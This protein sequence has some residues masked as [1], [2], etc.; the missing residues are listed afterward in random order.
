MYDKIFTERIKQFLDRLSKLKYSNAVPMSAE[1]LYDKNEPIPYKT[2]VKSKFKPIKV[3]DKWG[4]LW[5]CAWF[6]FKGEIPAEFE[7]CETGAL[8]DMDGEGCVF[9]KGGPDQGLTNKTDWYVNSGK[10]FY[11]ISDK[12]EAGKKF[13][14]MVEAGANGLFGKDKDEFRLKQAEIVSVDKKVMRLE[15]DMICLFDLMKKL[16][17]NTPRKKKLL[18]GLNGIVNIWDGGEGMDKAL[19]MTKEMLSKK[20][21]D[22]VMTVYSIGHAHIDLAWL[23]PVRETRRK[24][25]R[26]FS[27]ALKLLEEYPEYKFGSSQPQL[28]QWVKEDYPALYNNIKKAVKKGRWEV[29]GA[30]WVEPDM[31]ITSGESLVR[32]CLY[33]KKFFLEEFGIEVKNLWLPDV[34]GYSAALPQILIK[35][36]VDVFMT[37]KISWNE[38]NKFPHHT[39]YWKG[40]DGTDILTHFLP[41]NDYNLSNLPSKLIESEERYAQSDVSDEFL[42]LYGIGDGGGGPSPVHIELGMRQKDLEGTPKFKFSFAQEFFD[43]ISKIPKNDLP[44]WA[45]ELYLELHRGTYTTQSLMKKYNRDLEIAL[46]DLEFLGTWLKKYP[47]EEIDRIWKDTLLNQFHDILPGSSINR[48]YKEAHELSEKNFDK[49]H[50]L[51]EKFFNQLFD[52]RYDDKLEGSYLAFNSLSW[53]KNVL[54]RFPV[55]AGLNFKVTDAAGKNIPWLINHG[56]IEFYVKIPS[57]GYTVF[58]IAKD[59]VAAEQKHAGKA[60]LSITEKDIVLENKFIRV[61]IG[62]NGVINSIFDKEKNFETVKFANKLLMWEDMPINWEAWDI[63]H[64]Y[65]ETKPEQAQRVSLEIVGDNGHLVGIEQIMSIGNSTIVQEI[66]L[67]SDSREIRIENT[68]DWKEEHKLLKAVA[69]TNIMS[70]T[71]SY[72]IQYGKIKRPAH[73]NTSWD[74]AKFEVP[75]QRYADISQTDYGFAILNDCKYGHI[76]N[77]GKIELSLLRS[78]KS[79]DESA[80]IGKHIFIYSYYPHCCTLENSDTLKIAHELNDPASIIPLKKAPKIAE[81]SFYDIQTCSVKIETVKV[82][83]NGE[84]IIL[85]L[86]ETMGAS[87]NAVIRFDG[88]YDVSESNLIETDFKPLRK[89]TAEISLSF[90]PFEIRTLY[91]KKPEK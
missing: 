48:V 51:F 33:G 9:V 38:T 27:T 78:T 15:F 43:K 67:S 69:D 91:L 42:N 36:G 13:E 74:H 12:A 57:M 39:F 40:I 50:D 19:K 41:T 79:P 16:P 37:Q 46:R 90:K 49:L 61:S 1:Y 3:G 8:I 77:D 52:V 7:G 4:K 17:E 25:G 23:W 56:K 72:E 18:R 55:P 35:S 83:E 47:K 87:D 88:K 11:R 10:Y 65:R 71:A 86:Y 28:Y 81:K 45:G 80:D 34:F 22:S 82:S 2:A 54:V 89:K 30:M 73:F 20:A 60:E 58:S 32:Q 53:E 6:R 68:V 62:E 76:I 66:T 85:R 24:S 31:N 21:A 5:G 14:L 63:N 44:S 29:Q 26:T 59:K 84:G 64:Y 70:D 75:A